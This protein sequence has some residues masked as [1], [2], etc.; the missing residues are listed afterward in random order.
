MHQMEFLLD[1]LCVLSLLLCTDE[2]KTRVIFIQL[3]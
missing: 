2:A 3:L 1:E